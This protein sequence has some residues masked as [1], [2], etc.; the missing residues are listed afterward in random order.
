MYITLPANST[1]EDIR[2]QVATNTEI[3]YQ[4]KLMIG[5]KCVIAERRFT[6]K[7]NTAKTSYL[8]I[9]R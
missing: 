4:H 5:G 3:G 8:H 2:K 7:G 9:L 6:W 1:F